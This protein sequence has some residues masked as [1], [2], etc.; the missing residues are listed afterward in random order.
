M[1]STGTRSWASDDTLVSGRVSPLPLAVATLLIAIIATVA[2][3]AL[4][5]RGLHAGPTA[6]TGGQAASDAGAT[7]P[8]LATPSEPTSKA[9]GDRQTIPQRFACAWLADEGSLVIDVDGTARSRRE[10]TCPVTWS[11][12]GS[13]HDVFRA[14]RRGVCS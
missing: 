4:L 6:V 11:S 3:A 8:L 12:P 2:G 7:P 5:S 9:A 14:A 1:S 13:C 10:G